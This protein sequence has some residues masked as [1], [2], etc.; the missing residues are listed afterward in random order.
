M[1][2]DQLERLVTTPGISGREERI[3]AVVTEELKG[4][5]DEIE[6]DALGNVFGIR[7]GERPRVMLSAHMDSIGF[8]VKHID[9]NGFL[10]ISP[11]GGF[12]PRTLVSQHVLVLGKKD[13]VGLL[14]PSSKPIHILD[15]QE[16]K[17]APS[18]EDMFIDVMVPAEEVKANISVGDPVS[19][20][21]EPIATERAFT[22]PYLDDRL[23]VFVLLQA[24]ARADETACEIYAA[25]TVQEEVG[26]RGAATGAFGIE[27]DIGVALDITIAGD[28]PGADQSQQVSELGKGVAIKVMDSS[29]I[30]DPRLVDKLR[31]LAD[32]NGIPHQLE[33][34]PRGGTDAGGM[35]QA[36]SGVP[37]VT[38]SMPTR[39]V[40]TV[41]EMA[42]AADVEASIDLLARFLAG[43]HEIDL[44]R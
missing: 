43:A 39:Y 40:H 33:I 32:D 31:K 36:R 25:V 1:N 14:G 35:Q 44:R 37:V 34:L 38:V 11:V 3:R 18:L 2:W 27:P 22:S 5:V 19:L 10:R 16:R 21:Q 41:N 26:L 9:D 20:H 28:L 6:V 42:L 13:Y 24:L 7:R 29:S 17:K 30:S 23:G 12:D 15:E 8:L 4:L